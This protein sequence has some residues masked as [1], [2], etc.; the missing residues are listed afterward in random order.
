MFR[1]YVMERPQNDGTFCIANNKDEVIMLA[2]LKFKCVKI[3][4]LERNKKL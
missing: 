2:N 4:Y 1:K 3:F